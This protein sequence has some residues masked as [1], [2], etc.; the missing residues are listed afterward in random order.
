MVEIALLKTSC[1]RPSRVE[2]NSKLIDKGQFAS[3]LYSIKQKYC[4]RAL[5]LYSL[6]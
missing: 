4:E 5:L 1:D 3:Q 2:L 6:P